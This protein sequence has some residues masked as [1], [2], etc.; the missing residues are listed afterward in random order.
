M[1]DEEVDYEKVIRE[2]DYLHN[3]IQHGFKV[4]TFIKFPCP[5]IDYNDEQKDSYIKQYGFPNHREILRYEIFI[6]VDSENKKEGKKHADLVEARLDKQRIYYKRW[7]S[8]GD[9]EHFHLIYKKAD[10]DF[11]FKYYPLPVVKREI[12]KLLLGEKLITPKGIDSHICLYEKKLVQIEHMMHR[13]GCIKTMVKSRFGLNEMPKK[14]VD[15]LEGHKKESDNRKRNISEMMKNQQLIETK[16]I[17]FLEGATIN[18]K[19]IFKIN[20]GYYRA[21]FALVSEYKKRGYDNEKIHVK[22]AEWK[23]N[24]PKP[25]SPTINTF[26]TNYTIKH[27][28]GTAGCNFIRELL[29]ELNVSEICKDC[30]LSAK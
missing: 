26:K 21:M 5:W 17:P 23:T 3:N 7:K 2:L 16:C 19:N 29:E 27:S 15:I 14:I 6:D 25:I 1:K 11:L 22:I 8:G 24:I 10:M 18:G 4:Q 12:V 13:K 28:N 20:D 30:P 9:G